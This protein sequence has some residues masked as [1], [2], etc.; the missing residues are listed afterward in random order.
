[1]SKLIWITGNYTEFQLPLE[2]VLDCSGSGS[3]DDSVDY[4]QRTIELNIPRERIVKELSQYGAWE[5][6]EEVDLD[7]L[8]RRLIWVG[9]CNAR[10]EI[11][12]ENE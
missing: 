9:A 4:W 7:T 5:D 2:A 1:M 12:G 11:G 6:L 8:E 3:V 10:E